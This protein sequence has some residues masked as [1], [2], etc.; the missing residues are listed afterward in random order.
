MGCFLAIHQ[1]FKI[2]LY[3]MHV[4]TAIY[5][6]LMAYHLACLYLSPLLTFF[7]HF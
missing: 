7:H 5:S 3:G 4:L 6:V 2:S 1:H